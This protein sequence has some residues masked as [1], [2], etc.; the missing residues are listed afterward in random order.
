MGRQLVALIGP[1]PTTGR[2]AALDSTRLRAKGGVWHQK[3]REQGQV[4]PSSMNTEAGWSKSGYP[5]WGYGWKLHLASTLASIWIPLAAELTV[6]NTHASRRALALVRQL[7]EA[8]RFLLGDQ[9]DRAAALQQ[10]G[11]LTGRVLVTSQPGKDPHQDAGVEVRR[12]FHK[13][14]SKTI[15]PFNRRFKTIF[16]WGGPVPVRGCAPLSGW[17]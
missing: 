3:H 11:R 14:R 5:G 13:L 6:A 10:Q 12:S 1:Y 8:V 16:E 17:S 4:P 7:P 9:P 15:E 2:A